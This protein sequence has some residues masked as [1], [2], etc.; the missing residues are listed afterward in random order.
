MGRKAN[1]TKQVTFLL[2]AF[3]DKHKFEDVIFT[4]EST[5]QIEPYA[6]ISFRKK[7]YQPKLNEH[8]IHPLHVQYSKYHEYIIRI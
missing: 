7:G 3:T 2:Q 4:D 1:K 8:P 5:I 6:R